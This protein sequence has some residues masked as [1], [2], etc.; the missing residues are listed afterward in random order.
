VSA[1]VRPK[2]EGHLG[3][4]LAEPTLSV[5]TSPQPLLAAARRRWWVLALALLVG[6]SSGLAIG[7][8]MPSW[9][10]STATFALIPIDD[11]TGPSQSASDTGSAIPLF[12][13]VLT[14]R[15][16]EDEVVTQLQLTRAYEKATPEDARAE[17]HSHIAVSTDRRANMVV[18]SVEDRVPARAQMIARTLGEV[19]RDV[20]TEIWSARATEHRKRLEARL[21]E[22]SEALSSAEDAMRTFRDR[23][24]VADLE[25]Q[26]KASVNEAAFLERMRTE[27]RI[28]LHFAQA[29]D[30]PEL[31][32]KQL[33]A[34]G[35]QQALQGLVHGGEKMQRGPMLALDDVPRLKLEHA[36]LKREIDTNA[37]MHELLVRQVEQLRAVEARPGGRAELVDAPAEPRYRVRPSHFALA[38]QGCFIGLV[39][40]LLVIWPRTQIIEVH[41][42]LPVVRGDSPR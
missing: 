35:A 16:V 28:G 41:P 1:R 33:E 31:K 3:L 6:G 30:A 36:R 42:K 20:S 23:E 39:L 19:G 25:E 21:L 27:K 29:A 24:H 9:Y 5:L 11:P 15:R 32:Q 10:Q 18:L 4:A 40:A 34:G 2:I 13:Q 17:L 26:V 14:S 8:L 12:S 22:V 7:R 38:L 37:A